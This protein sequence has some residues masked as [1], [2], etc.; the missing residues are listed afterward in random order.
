MQQLRHDHIVSFRGIS[1]DGPNAML[2]MEYC[3]GEH[4]C[5]MRKAS[6]R[7]SVG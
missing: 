6:G 2:I 1:L 7:L 5:D 4:S 3:P